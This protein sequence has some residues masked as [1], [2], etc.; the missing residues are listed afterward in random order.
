MQKYRVIYQTSLSEVHQKAALSSA[1]ENL[2]VV[3]RR[4]PSREEM[5]ELIRDADFLISER[6]GIIDNELISGAPGLKL[7]QRIGRRSYDIDLEYAKK[8]GV[9]VCTQPIEKA[10]N[11]S[12]H[13]M[14]QILTL[15]KYTRRS[16]DIMKP[17]ASWD[18]EPQKCDEDTFAINWTGI[19]NIRSLHNMTI[20]ILGFGEIGHELALRLKP[21]RSVILYNKR[22]KLPLSVEKKLGLQYR[23]RDAMF[24]ESDIICSLLPLL[25]G[26]PGSINKLTINLMKKGSFIVH[27]GASSTVN[28]KDVAEAL[29]SGQLGGF[30]ADTF[31]WEPVEPDNP[32]L[33]VSVNPAINI[34]LTPHIAVGSVSRPW[35]DSIYLNI[36]NYLRGESLID[37]VI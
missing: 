27:C 8:R 9:V 34:V 19:K 7:I 3:I 4:D 31:A 2:D 36:T 26:I 29:K 17:E 37:R 1:P 20:G 13:M 18:R 25:P 11:V 33:A 35:F 32:L 28:E 15:S 14:M 21:F 16:M 10:L 12:E 30:A 5:I 23:D 6:E 24:R 22:K